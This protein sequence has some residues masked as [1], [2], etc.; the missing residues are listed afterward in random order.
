MCVCVCT[1]C[2][3]VCSKSNEKECKLI[4]R[5]G[6]AIKNYKVSLDGLHFA[7]FYPAAAAAVAG[8]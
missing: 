3:I 1:L 8:C 4:S 6:A 5:L 7:I 2:N